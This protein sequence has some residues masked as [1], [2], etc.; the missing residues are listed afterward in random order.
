MK[1]KL[2]TY[3]YFSPVSQFQAE[4]KPETGDDDGYSSEG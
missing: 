3:P 1:G 4:E 2:V